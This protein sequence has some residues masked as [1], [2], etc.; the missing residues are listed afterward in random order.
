M[1]ETSAASTTTN[2]SS[3]SLAPLSST[4]PARRMISS[5]AVSCFPDVCVR[6]E[7]H[8][9]I[10]P[11]GPRHRKNLLANNTRTDY[12]SAGSLIPTM[13]GPSP[14]RSAR[15]STVLAITIPS[16]EQMRREPRKAVVVKFAVYARLARRRP[17]WS[18]PRRGVFAVRRLAFIP[19]PAAV[20]QES[21]KGQAAAVAARRKRDVGSTAVNG[22]MS[23]RPKL[24]I[25]DGM[26]KAA[27][28]SV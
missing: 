20:K 2:A 5:A 21:S 8:R 1:R 27:Y 17:S 10:P 15:T 7:S 23:Y 18:I 13:K 25:G 6:D 3:P 4:I 19:C 16:L 26:K 11:C 14:R 22:Q 24:W 28:P 9:P 12:W